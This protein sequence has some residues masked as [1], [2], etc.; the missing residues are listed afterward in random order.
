MVVYDAVIQQKHD[1]ARMTATSRFAPS[2]SAYFVR[3]SICGTRTGA[4]LA[5]GAFARTALP[6]SCGSKQSSV[7][8]SRQERERARGALL[9]RAAERRC[10]HR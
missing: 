1:T 5:S 2:H 4:P 7:S 10:L 8:S 6:T 9:A 3:L